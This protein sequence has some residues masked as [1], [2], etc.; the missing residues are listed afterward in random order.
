MSFF[1]NDADFEQAELYR[2]GRLASLR[3]KQGI[4]THDSVVGYLAQPI[5][6]EQIGLKPGQERCTSGCGRIFESRDA[7]LDAMHEA[8]ND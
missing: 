2:R 8:L 4:C 6:P 5:Y 7:W 1:E 3:R